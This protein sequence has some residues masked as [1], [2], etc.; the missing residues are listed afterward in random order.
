L[1]L[2]DLIAAFLH[3][4]K[5]ETAVVLVKEK[6]R[7]ATAENIAR[8]CCPNSPKSPEGVGRDDLCDLTPSLKTVCRFGV[9]VSESV[10]QESQPTVSIVIGTKGEYL[11]EMVARLVED[12]R[13]NNEKGGSQ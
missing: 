12:G 10:E 7:F 3:F 5:H 8:V 13:R 2:A 1:S 11:T 6:V 9:L 4:H